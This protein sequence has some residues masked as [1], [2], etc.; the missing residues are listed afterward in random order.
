M[1][2]QA[3]PRLA[4]G[5]STTTT[6]PS[7]RTSRLSAWMSVWTRV[8]PASACRPRPANSPNWSRWLLAQ[9][10]RSAGGSAATRC[11]PCSSAA[12]MTAV[13]GTA[14]NGA[15]VSRLA[16]GDV[17]NLGG[18]VVRGGLAEADGDDGLLRTGP[19]PDQPDVTGGPA[20]AAGAAV[21]DFDDEGLPVG[22]VGLAV[23]LG[24]AGR[25]AVE[26]R[27]ADRVAHDR[28]RLY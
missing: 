4:H 13:A 18:Q 15:G 21:V 22:R 3:G 9:G 27:S 10:S 1:S 12:N 17:A 7:A 20:P 5:Q 6:L 19:E 24:A 16:R 14:G 23:S 11:Q 28:P 26:P 8:V 25:T 2:S